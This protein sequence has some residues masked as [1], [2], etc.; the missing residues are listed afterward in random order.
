MI[1]YT[2]IRDS[3]AHEEST[4]TLRGVVVLLLGEIEQLRR[5]VTGVDPTAEPAFGTALSDQIRGRL[6]QTHDIAAMR[7]LAREAFKGLEKLDVQ[8]TRLRQP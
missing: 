5:S 3:I 2:G 8:L 4:E 7:S 6:S 1:D